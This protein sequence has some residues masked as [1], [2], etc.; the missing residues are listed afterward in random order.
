MDP[1]GTIFALLIKRKKFQQMGFWHQN[2]KES[3]PFYFRCHNESFVIIF[4][5][6]LGGAHPGYEDM[7]LH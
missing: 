7:I 6:W 3:K 5:Y 4:K 1:P 2:L